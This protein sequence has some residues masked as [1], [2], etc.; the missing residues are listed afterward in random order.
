LATIASTAI[1]NPY[2]GA[3]AAKISCLK[4]DATGVGSLGAS[5]TGVTPRAAN[6]VV[7]IPLN[8]AVPNSY[9]VFSEVSYQYFPVTGFSPGFCHISAFGVTLSDVMYMAPRITPPK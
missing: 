7:T 8:L 6:E 3:V 5:T 2:T 4:I 1:M 9:L